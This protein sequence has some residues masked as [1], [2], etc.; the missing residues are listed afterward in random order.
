MHK[1]GKHMLK[2]T[3]VDKIIENKNTPNKIINLDSGFIMFI[4][5]T[6]PEGFLIFNKDDIQNE[7]IQNEKFNIGFE[8][9]TTLLHFINGYINYKKKDNEPII[10][11]N[12]KVYNE[13]E[14]NLPIELLKIFKF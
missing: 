13:M 8:T 3:S 2:S 5:S 14:C 6:I 10:N 9:N 11:I 12:K 7:I 4:D 1:L